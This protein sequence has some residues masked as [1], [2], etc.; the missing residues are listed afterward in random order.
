VKPA[1]GVR[2]VVTLILPV[3]VQATSKPN[4][5]YLRYARCIGKVLPALAISTFFPL[6]YCEILPIGGAGVQ[7]KNIIENNC[8]SK[9]RKS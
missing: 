9:R 4:M 3:S 5:L 2:V 7:F 1:G 6:F 8:V